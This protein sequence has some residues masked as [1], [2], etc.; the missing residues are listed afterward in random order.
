MINDVEKKLIKIKFE[1]IL[2]NKKILKKI[3]SLL[4]KNEIY[5]LIIL[6]KKINQTIILENNFIFLKAITKRDDDFLFI[7]RFKKEFKNISIIK[8]LLLE[9]DL[10]Y[11]DLY[12]KLNFIVHF[13][14]FSCLI[15]FE[16]FCIILTFIPGGKENSHLIWVTQIPFLILYIICLISFI[17]YYY[18]FNK[19]HK[20]INQF[21]KSEI[22][23][24]NEKQIKYLAI[25]LG[26]RINNQQPYAF[27]LI[28]IIFIF[29]YLPV[30]IK[31]FFQPYINFSYESSFQA[32]MGIIFIFYILKDIFDFILY[33]YKHR[34]TKVTLYKKIY[35]EGKS[36]FFNEK[37]KK[38]K[39]K[40]KNSFCGENCMNLCN[41]IVKLIVFS[42]IALYLEG[43]G[44]KLDNYKIKLS[45]KV[46]FI[47]AYFF[48]IF[49]IIWGCIFIY[50]LTKIKMKFKL[51]LYM[52]LGI[53]FVCL[54]FNCFICPISLDNDKLKFPIY[55]PFLVNFFLLC[56]VIIHYF[57]IK[58]QKH[59][60]E[61]NEDILSEENIT[62]NTKLKHKL[63]SG[64][65]R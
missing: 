32:I 1:N 42:F 2:N 45:W 21:I 7:L 38:L 65:I 22:M 40:K 62:I 46:L 24:L 31:I 27:K 18:Y 10:L 61:Y 4:E 58:N 3:L 55:L 11:K 49:N 36:D 29:G 33:K 56:A 41:F 15:L 6:N 35:N 13:F 53:I 30:V 48:C 44:K 54:I 39:S 16:I 14:Y 23:D 60:I 57:I 25:K 37:M 43:L 50:S 47:P 17:L 52:T 12:K 20:N 51:L 9:S 28:C 59:N 8:K 34:I 5:N 64:E 63:S 19:S 26:Y